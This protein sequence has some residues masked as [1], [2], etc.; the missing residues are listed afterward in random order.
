M[1]LL[2]LEDRRSSFD[3][4]FLYKVLN[5]YISI[6]INRHIIQ[7]YSDSD[8]YHLRGKKNLKQDH[9]IERAISSHGAVPGLSPYDKIFSIFRTNCAIAYGTRDR[10]SVLETE[11][12]CQ[13]HMISARDR[14][15]VLGTE[16]SAGQKICARDRRSL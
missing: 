2:S 9:K 3:V 13:G 14:K 1:N 8:S 11:D 16:I 7:F 5:W 12:Q 6:D 10:R 4:L 15:S